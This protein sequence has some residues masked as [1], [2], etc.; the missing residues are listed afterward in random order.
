MTDIALVWNAAEGIADLAMNGPD[1]LTDNGLETAVILSL[2]SDRLAQPGDSIPDGT[3]DRRGWWGDMP[4]AASEQDTTPPA[5]AIYGSRLLLLD[6]G[7]GTT[8]TLRQAEAYA[9]EALAWMTADG[10]A[11]AVSATATFPRTGTIALSI[12]IEQAGGAQTYSYAWA[13]TS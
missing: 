7:L 4:I 13:A 1:L 9:R 8:Q 10:V 5:T 3:S 6:R 11:G 2:F 12:T